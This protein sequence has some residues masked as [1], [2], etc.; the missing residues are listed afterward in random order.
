MEIYCNEC[1]NEMQEGYVIHDGLY[2]YC[3]DECLHKNITKD[4]Y[5]YLYEQG[6]SFWTTFE[7]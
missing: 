1:H 6:F 2:H 5:E 7:D 3:S 4:D